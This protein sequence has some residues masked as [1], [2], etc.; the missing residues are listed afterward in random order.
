MRCFLE[1]YGTFDGEHGEPGV[2]TW[3][4]LSR[5]YPAGFHGTVVKSQQMIPKLTKV[6]AC[7][8]HFAPNLKPILQDRLQNLSIVYGSEFMKPKKNASDLCSE[9]AENFIIK[10]LQSLGPFGQCHF[11]IQTVGLFVVRC[12]KG[13]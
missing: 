11:A 12:S 9:K 2:E 13:N 4:M 7:V 1:Q 5:G 3:Q 6:M 10:F 8:E